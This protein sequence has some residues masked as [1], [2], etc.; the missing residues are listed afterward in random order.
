MQI[1]A[2]R[3]SGHF[4]PPPNTYTHSNQPPHGYLQPTTNN[5][6]HQ[7]S[8]YL[9]SPQNVHIRTDRR[10]WAFLT[11][12]P[13][14]FYIYLYTIQEGVREGAFVSLGAL[15]RA[16]NL[17]LSLTCEHDSGKEHTCRCP[18]LSCKLMPCGLQGTSHRPQT[19]TH[20]LFTAPT[21]IFRTHYQF[22]CTGDNSVAC[23]A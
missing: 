21:W 4:T 11:P 15:K 17:F 13:P 10:F 19:H 20:T 18:I 5:W 1:D 8:S 9:E 6:V 16:L 14:I 2:L 23:W 7:R 3:S 22:I 12:S